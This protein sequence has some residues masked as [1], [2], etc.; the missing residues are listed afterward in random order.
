M[1]KKKVKKIVK[2]NL[3]IRKGDQVVVVA[4]ADK[5]E[6]G[7]VLTVDRRK[8]RAIVEG[9]NMVSRHTR[10]DTDN[11]DGGIIK[12]EAGVHVSNLMLID[13]KSGKPTRTG[14]K[15][16][17]NKKVRFAKKSGEVID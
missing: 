5:G 12:Q 8:N 1:P 10:P 17:G 9:I 7:K 11:P 2:H 3:H 13:P 14:T 15:M 4:G 6:Q 16:D